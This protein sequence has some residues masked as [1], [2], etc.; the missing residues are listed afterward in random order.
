VNNQYLLVLGVLVRVNGTNSQDSLTGIV[1]VYKDS[2][3]QILCSFTFTD[4]D[5][6]VTCKELGYMRGKTLPSAAFGHQK[7]DYTDPPFA[8]CKGDETSILNCSFSD[9][10][11]IN[12]CK[13][14]DTNYAAIS[15]YNA[16]VIKP[17]N[18]HVHIR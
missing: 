4:K 7:G 15:C 16:S 14:S 9:V 1:E 8:V 6:E 13:T 10:S 5:A 11:Q 3:W 2:S 18:I 12:I 17:G